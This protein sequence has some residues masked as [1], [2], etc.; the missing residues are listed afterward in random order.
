MT[1]IA[2]DSRQMPAR[3]GLD[4]AADRTTPK[5]T[6]STAEITEVDDEVLEGLQ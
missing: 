4:T 6:P 1:A 5:T 2:A 3:R